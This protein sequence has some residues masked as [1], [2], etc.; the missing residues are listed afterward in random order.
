MEGKSVVEPLLDKGCEI[1]YRFRGGI[2][3]EF[4]NDSSFVRFQDCIGI[5]FVT[6]IGGAKDDSSLTITYD[7]VVGISI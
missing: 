2:G 3:V 5:G 7:F 4:D 1:I 6:P